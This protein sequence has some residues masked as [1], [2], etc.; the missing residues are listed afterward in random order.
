MMS[1]D[2]IKPGQVFSVFGRPQ[3]CAYRVKEIEIDGDPSRWRVHDIKV[4]NRPQGQQAFRHPIPGERFRKGGIMSDLRLEACQ[5]TMDFVM[6]VEY[7]GPLAEGEV[8]EATLV[9]T[10][11]L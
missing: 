6:E 1:S 8:F 2:R 3:L 4:G 9:R 11:V 7:V 10:I 5:T